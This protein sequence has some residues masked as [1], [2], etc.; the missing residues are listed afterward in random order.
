MQV[1]NFICSSRCWQGLSQCPTILQKNPSSTQ[2]VLKL[3][4]WI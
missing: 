1:V 4:S 3:P 2:A